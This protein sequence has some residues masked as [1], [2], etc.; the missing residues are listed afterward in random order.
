[1]WC[2]LY[3]TLLGAGGDLWRDV[4]L[5]QCLGVETAVDS[6]EERSVVQLCGAFLDHSLIIP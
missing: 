2:C 4:A 6:L 3:K 5:I 1:M